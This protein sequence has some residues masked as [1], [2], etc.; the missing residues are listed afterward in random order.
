MRTQPIY[1]PLTE[2]GRSHLEALGQE[3]QALQN[4]AGGL[5]RSAYGKARG[6]ALRLALY[7]NLWW[8]GVREWNL[9]PM[10]QRP[11]IPCRRA[12]CC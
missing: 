10:H 1:V 11:G 3:M 9:L 12:T 4:W 5:M 7:W 2:A 8:R 6:L